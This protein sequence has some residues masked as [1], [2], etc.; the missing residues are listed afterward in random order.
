MYELNAEQV[1]RSSTSGFEREKDTVKTKRKGG[2]R[3]E[4]CV[5]KVESRYIISSVT[6]YSAVN[7]WT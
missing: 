5:W 7:A 3:G 6:L 4:G 1:L 2:R